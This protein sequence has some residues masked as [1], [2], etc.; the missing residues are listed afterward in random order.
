VNFTIAA[1]GAP[2]DLAVSPALVRSQAVAG[3]GDPPDQSVLLFNTGTGPLG[4]LSVVGVTYTNGTGWLDA[5]ESGGV[6]TL[7]YDVSGLSADTFAASVEVSSVQ[8]GNETVGVTLVLGRPVLTLSS[9][10]AGFAGPAGG[11][12]SPTTASVQISNTGAGT[13]AS[14]G[15]V[16]LGPTSYVG[17]GGWLSPAL[18]AGGTRVDLFATIGTLAPGTYQARV[19]VESAGAGA[20]SIAVTLTVTRPADAPVLSLSAS[21]VEFTAIL[22]GRSPA[23]RAVFLTNSGGG[24]LADLGSL[25]LGTITYGAGPTGW[26][27]T[28]TLTGAT[29]TLSPTTSGLGAGTHTATVAVISQFGG[30]RT[31]SVSVRIGAPVLTASALSLSFT[32]Q[33]GGSAPARQTL[34]FTNAGAGAFSDLGLPVVSA[35]TYADSAGGWLDLPPLGQ[36]VPAGTLEVE[37]NQAGLPPGAYSATLVVSSQPGGVQAITVSLTVV[38]ASDPPL[39]LL[40]PDSLRFD[41]LVGGAHP[42]A[43][44]VAVSNAGGGSLGTVRTAAVA[45][46]TG[47]SG[48]LSAAAAGATLSLEAATGTLPTG[49]YTATV[50]VSSDGGTQ[51]LF[52]SFVVG[53]SRLTVSPRTVSF[54]DTARGP[55]PAPVLVGLANSGGGTFE[56]LGAIALG[57]ASYGSGAQ[58]WLEAILVSPTTVRLRATTGDLAARREA[59]LARVALES[60]SGGSDTVTVAFTVAPGNVLARLELSQASLGFAGVVGGEAPPPQPVS[61]FNS[62]G[63]ELGALSVGGI[64]YEAA[65]E[66]WLAASVEGSSVRVGANP[67]GL[68]EGAHRATVRIRSENGGE[69]PLTVTL[70]LTTPRLRLSTESILFSDTVG[71]AEPLRTRVFLSNVGAGTRESLGP[72]QVGGIQY[73]DGPAAWLVTLPSPGVPVEGY[74]VEIAASALGLPAGTFQARVPLVSTW[75]GSDTVTVSLTTREPDRSFDLPTIELVKDSLVGGSPVPVPLPGDS[76]VVGPAGTASTQLSVRVG[77]RNGSRTRLTLSGLR[78]GIPSYP[79]GQSGGW[80]TGAFLNR[81]AA[82]YEDPAELFVA[83]ESRGLAP[84]RYEGR[85]VVSSESAGLEAV[86]PRVL[87]VVLV[88]G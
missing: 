5:R 61:V 28:S 86:L 8:G 1:T 41:A 56:S 44:S 16:S 77:V 29:L 49:S 14:L 65:G 40:S 79:P 43:Q 55:G 50:P 30:T 23:S 31:L 37:P 71:S 38:R 52:V 26:L 36:T 72:L 66:G 39:M 62:G 58:G 19:P 24:S 85:L 27:S 87:R 7:G 74:Q 10:S 70:T 17:A 13:F 48:W 2:A 59:Y 6:L 21:A 84:G 69:R 73:A 83:V 82:T 12:A 67:A 80:I 53:S 68:Q 47:A 3:G 9:S 34:T 35:V 18:A 81:T 63:G 4:A 76:V 88:V 54:G 22:A 11:A 64:E 20:D 32:G 75:G 33:E 42:P 78:V 51:E 45:Y 15:T 60:A 46:G 57:A 25:S